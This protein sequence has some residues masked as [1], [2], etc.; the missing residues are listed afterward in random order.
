MTKNEF[1]EACECRLIDP[2]IALDASDALLEAL[3]ARDDVRVIEILET[4][5]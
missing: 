5:F 4:E 3:K 1:V 2:I